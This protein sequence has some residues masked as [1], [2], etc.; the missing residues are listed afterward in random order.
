MMKSMMSRV[1][2]YI[3]GGKPDGASRLHLGCR[4]KTV[5]F[6]SFG[7]IFKGSVYYAGNSTMWGGGV[8][9][10]DFGTDDYS[11]GRV[12]MITR[13]QFEYVAAQEC[14]L[15]A[16]MKGINFEAL[17]VEDVANDKSLLYGYS[18]LVGYIS[19][20]PVVSFTN[21]YSLYEVT[22]GFAGLNLN[23]PSEA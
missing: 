23:T 9:F 17:M 4:D 1:M 2:C 12:H 20:T 11:L 16:G 10:A 14:G 18:V 7:V 13:E 15:E 22:D 6:E 3:A 8:L 19:G 21:G 5:P